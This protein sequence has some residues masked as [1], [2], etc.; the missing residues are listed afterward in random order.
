MGRSKRVM[1]RATSAM[2]RGKDRLRKMSARAL[3]A[4]TLTDDTPIYRYVSAEVFLSMIERQENWLAHISRWEDPFEGFVFRGEALEVEPINDPS[5]NVARRDLYRNYF[6][7]S[8]TLCDKDSDLRWRAY[9]PQRD[10]VRI[11][12]TV[13]RLKRN[14]IGQ[15]KQSLAAASHFDKVYYFNRDD[16]QK[17]SKQKVM[18]ADGGFEMLFV[19]SEE[20]DEEQE[21]RIVVDAS[22][23]HNVMAQKGM[24]IENGFLKYPL[25]V[26]DGKGNQ[27]ALF[28]EI[29]VDPRMDVLAVERLKS[30][31]AQSG[32]RLAVRQSQAYKWE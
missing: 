32:A 18:E 7:Q 25:G 29:L 9:C 15:S 16:L 24:R 19:K 4:V 22:L 17:I 14:F 26:I 1:Q 21:Y 8:W 5:V 3:R 23:L 27:R 13:G 6:G 2:E 28:D 31:V 30:R 11:T 20:F 12:S 10:G